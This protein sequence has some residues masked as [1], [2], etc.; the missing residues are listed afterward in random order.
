MKGGIFGPWEAVAG[1]YG[2]GLG[3][4]ADPRKPANKAQAQ[5][6]ATLGNLA[7]RTAKDIGIGLADDIGIPLGIALFAGKIP[8]L[9]RIQPGILKATGI[10]GFAFSG[11]LMGRDYL[12]YVA[13]REY[14]AKSQSQIP[15]KRIN[16]INGFQSGGP[17]AAQRT[18]MT[19]IAS[20]AAGGIFYRMWH[21][22]A[23]N[24]INNTLTPPSS[25]TSD[26]RVKALAY[27]AVGGFIGHAAGVRGGLGKAAIFGLSGAMAG[28]LYG[29]HQSHN[30][31]LGVNLQA[32]GEIA[33]TALPTTA[34]GTGLWA[35]SRMNNGI[36]RGVTRGIESAVRY[37]AR[38]GARIQ[39]LSNSAYETAKTQTANLYRNMGPL[40]QRA[41][42][43]SFFRAADLA[44][45]QLSGIIHLN[46][47]GRIPMIGD[48]PISMAV[49]GGIF[50][51]GIA[52]GKTYMGAASVGNVVGHDFVGKMLV[53]NGTRS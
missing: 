4:Q 35:L 50:H 32:L 52:M 7:G 28:G 51:G 36:G 17:G 15:D 25:H 53:E 37:A 46:S 23:A 12:E 5:D 47:H 16:P 29:I 22:P 3:L 18:T 2:L 13:A 43:N 9:R 20:P 44:T 42:D 48:A 41:V 14:L 1:V 45:S 24:L 6:R 27:A 19:G 30:P 33:F 31:S 10:A 34:L 21:N 11:A 26:P 49:A 8:A 39:T 40:S 38:R